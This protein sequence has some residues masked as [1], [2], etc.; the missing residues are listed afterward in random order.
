MSEGH[1][2]VRQLSQP[3][4]DQPCHCVD[5]VVLQAHCVGVCHTTQHQPLDRSWNGNMKR[6]TYVINKIYMGTM[7]LEKY[8]YSCAC[9]GA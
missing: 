8:N 4:F 6:Y 1:E 9:V 2:G 5:G 7:K 3:L